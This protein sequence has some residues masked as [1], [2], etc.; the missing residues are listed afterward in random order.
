MTVTLSLFAGVGAQ[1]LDNNGNILSG[2]LIYTY[3][4][5]TTTPLATFTTN[6][7]N[8]AQPNPIVLDSAGR[9]S[10]G[11]L[12]LSNGFGYKF[13]V[14][15]SNGVLIGTYDNVPSSEQPPITNDAS[16]I[17]YE[18]G[19]STI[20]GSFIIGNTYL[21]TYIGSTNFQ[22]IGASSN[23]VGLHFIAT[24]VGSGTGTAQISRTVQNKLQ[25]SVSILDF[26]VIGDGITDNTALIQKAINETSF[27]K[28]NLYFNG[29]GVYIVDTLVMKSNMHLFGDG[30][31]TLKLK[32]NASGSILFSN[33]SI[34]NLTLNG[35]ILD[36]NQSN[37]PPDSNAIHSIIYAN[38]TVTF[39]DFN[40][41]NNKFNNSAYMVIGYLPT[42][43]NSNILNNI[44]SNHYSSCFVININNCSISNNIITNTGVVGNGAYCISVSGSNNIVS[45]NNITLAASAGS[46]GCIGIAWYGGDDS[47]NLISG[48][49]I[50]CLNSSVNYAIS[51]AG[52]TSKGN[53]YLG[54]VFKNGF[55]YTDMELSG[56]TNIIISNN[57]HINSKSGITCFNVNKAI[58][59]NLSFLARTDE[60]S[61]SVVGFA[62]NNSYV[63]ISNLM[64]SGTIEYIT[65]VSQTA[66][67]NISNVSAETISISIAEVGYTTNCSNINISNINIG[68]FLGDQPFLFGNCTNVA[69]SNVNVAT[70]TGSP[71]SVIYSS[72][73]IISSN[74]NGILI[75]AYTSAPT[76]GSWLKSDIVY[77]SNPTSGTFAGWICLVAGTPGTWT[78][79]GAIT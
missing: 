30:N 72:T 75:P 50:D 36:G 15:D 10:G 13:V 34:S 76:T 31:T 46:I 28:Q 27:A 70:M 66:S 18:E 56:E 64:I 49:N 77:N 16:S 33:V 29:G 1:F 4:A 12:W 65:T 9:I 60:S 44:I 25:E 26:G 24:G 19:N 22:L 58:I 40:I 20:A 41:T 21:I 67:L 7:G 3:N 23:T 53:K 62:G 42:F 71:T 17:Y 32:N 74:L 51:S 48:N 69:V 59:S 73:N 79:F 35:L 63:S 39:T 61:I 57:S 38:N 43:I 11:E 2:G 37:N 45:N 47:F 54:N 68:T 52:I 78:T 6:L 55:F 14:K 5:G 8:V